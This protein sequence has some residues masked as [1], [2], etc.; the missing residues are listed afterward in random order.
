MNDSWKGFGALPDLPDPD[1][2][3][4]SP[5]IREQ[6]APAAADGPADRL[7]AAHLDMLAVSARLRAELADWDSAGAL[8][9]AHLHDCLSRAEELKDRIWRAMAR[10]A[11][12][13]WGPGAGAK[14]GEGT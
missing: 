13:T 6:P 3:P 2:D 8:G 10:Q 12:G 5:A 7:A 14:G 9:A 11:T 1:P 4:S